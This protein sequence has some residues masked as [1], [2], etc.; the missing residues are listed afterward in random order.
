MGS[1]HASWLTLCLGLLAM[2]ACD[3]GSSGSG[4][5][6]TGVGGNLGTAGQ[7]GYQGQ[8]QSQI[9]IDGTGQF[10][11]DDNVFGVQGRWYWTSDN[12]GTVLN[13]VPPEVPYDASRNGMCLSGSTILNTAANNYAAWGS[14]LGVSLNDSGTKV[15]YDAASHGFD[16]IVITTTGS[17]GGCP[18]RVGFTTAA[19]STDPAPFVQLTETGQTEISISDAVVPANWTVANAGAIANPNAI[20]DIQ[21]QLSSTETVACDFDFCVTKVAFAGPNGVPS[22]GGAQGTGG[23][24]GAGTGSSG[25]TAGAPAQPLTGWLGFAAQGADPTRIRS[26]YDRWR[27]LFFK[28]CGNGQAYVF[29]NDTNDVVSEGI[30]YGMLLSANVGEQSDF[31]KL[32]QYYKAR[33]NGNGVMNWNYPASCSGGPKAENG[34]SDAE[35]DAAMALL[36]AAKNGWGSTYQSDAVALIN[37]IKTHETV[38]CSG[39]TMLKPG[40][41]W[42]DDC[43]DLNPS[44]FSPGYYRVFGQVTNDTSFWNTMASDAYWLLSQ[45]QSRLGGL[46]P[47]WGQISGTLGGRTRGGATYGYDACRTPWRVATDYCWFGTA[48]AKTF[49]QTVNTQVILTSY[50]PSPYNAAEGNNNSAYVGSFALVGTAI[51]QATANAYFTNWLDAPYLDDY[52]SGDEKYYQGTLRV[53]YLMLYGGRFSSSL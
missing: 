21:F 53:L 27:G 20:Y 28:D 10:V 17:L 30:A 40:D 33:R 7:G 22:T 6:V 37:A 44:Y 39:R 2:G 50:P 36:V 15:P 43:L 25:G 49:L 8:A 9:P 18:L 14:A 41:V 24:G 23:S 32:W 16:R 4:A 13:P 34:A 19:S 35:L 29:K 38:S 3:S 12:V 42:G 11:P 48:E 1:V 52:V 46:V 51:D 5:E 26:E 45:F 31:D 47:D